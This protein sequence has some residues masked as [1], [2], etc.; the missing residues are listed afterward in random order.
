MRNLHPADQLAEV[1][2]DLE[3]LKAKEKFLRTLLLETGDFRGEE[4]RAH[5]QERSQQRLD[6]VAAKQRYGELLE[7]FQVTQTYTILRLVRVIGSQKNGFPPIGK[8]CG[9]RAGW[10]RGNALDAA[11]VSTRLR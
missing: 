3:D 10:D 11:Q 5:P 6:S 9:K 4:W 2:K 7:P 8:R 1:R